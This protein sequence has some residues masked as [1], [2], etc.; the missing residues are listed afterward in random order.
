M[1]LADTLLRVM[2]LPIE[3]FQCYESETLIRAISYQL[4]W[5]FG[6]KI[7]HSYVIRYFQEI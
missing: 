2:D 1:S 4:I 6:R 3:G 5:S 7:L